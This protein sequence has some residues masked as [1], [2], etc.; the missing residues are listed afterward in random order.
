MVRWYRLFLMWVFVIAAS[1]FGSCVM[2]YLL[3]GEW[4][5]GVFMGLAMGVFFSAGLTAR[6]FTVPVEQLPSHAQAP[7]EKSS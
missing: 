6:G 2:G 4:R 3:V 7:R 1:L 5:Y